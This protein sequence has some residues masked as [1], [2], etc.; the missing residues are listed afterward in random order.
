[1]NNVQ[2]LEGAVGWV[3]SQPVVDGVEPAIRLVTHNAV[4]GVL[5]Q[6][7][8]AGMYGIYGVCGMGGIECMCTNGACNKSCTRAREWARV[9]AC[10]MCALK[11]G[12]NA[13]SCDNTACVPTFFIGVSMLCLSVQAP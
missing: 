2:D 4:A 13:S 6:T 8:R 7:G 10:D 5:M 1:M 12:V 3:S 9:Y 11:H